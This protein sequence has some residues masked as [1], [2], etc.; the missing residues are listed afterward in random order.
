[1]KGDVRVRF[2]P[3]PTGALH[4]GGAHTALFNW[5][6]ARKNGGTF[7]LRIEDTDRARSTKEYE[8][9]IMKG[10]QW[11]GLD[12]DE[13]PVT[14]GPY[15]PYRQSERSHLYQENAQRLL[16]L[17]LAYKDGD[18]IIF[19]V[20]KGKTIAFE[21]IVYGNISMES[22]TLKDIVLI[23]SDGFPTYNFA[24]VVDDYL[25]NITYVIRGEDHISNTPKQI[26]LYEALGWRLPR[27]AHLPMILG[28]DKKKLSKR[29]GAT[30]V[31]EYRDM[32]YLPEGLFNYFAL[33]GWSP[34]DNQEIFDRDEAVRLFDLSR[35]TKRAAVF[36]MDKLDAVNQIHISRL[37]PQKRVEL[38]KPFWKELGLEPENLNDEFLSE[39]LELLQGRGKTLRE[40]AVF[41]D[42]FL[43][44]EVVKK[45]YDGSDISDSQK[46][47]LREFFTQLFDKD[48]WDAHEMASFAKEWSKDKGLKMKD[49]AMPFRMVITGTKVS[50]GIFEV[51]ALLGKEETAKRLQ[52]YGL[53]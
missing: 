32:G 46:S 40:V 44:F 17:G 16:D 25:M 27:F 22:E 41:S 48:Q 18:A 33:L 5:L 47:L 30:S 26:L 36:D 24:V 13:G 28:K 6:W 19:S 45:R 42:Y 43:T 3:S 23:K 7:V 20:P 12:W 51:A 15:G 1:M 21:D 2:A 53:L 31:Y 38:V 37:D 35:V 4:I 8:E 9:T 52:Y 50:P 11:L 14:G 10:L 29:H 49:V 34:G 39:A